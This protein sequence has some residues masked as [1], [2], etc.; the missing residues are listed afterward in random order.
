MKL[1]TKK[2][3]HLHQ[4]HKLY[5]DKKLGYVHIDDK[6]PLFEASVFCPNFIRKSRNSVIKFFLRYWDQ[7][8]SHLELDGDTMEKIQQII[9]KRNE[10]RKD[11]SEDYDSNEE[12]ED[13]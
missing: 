12:N 11:N 10:N 9:K 2:Y 3:P 13:V 4:V 1:F 5:V 7:L 6:R 8:F